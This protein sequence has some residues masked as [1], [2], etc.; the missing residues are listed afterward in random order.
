MDFSIPI[1]WTSQFTNSGV[2]GAFFYFDIIF[3]LNSCNQI[4]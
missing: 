3:N 4:V 1:N 2:A